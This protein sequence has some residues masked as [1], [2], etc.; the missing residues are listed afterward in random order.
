MCGIV[1]FKSEKKLNIKQL[2][3]CLKTLEY[4]G[5]DS[6]GVAY[7]KNNKI[8]IIKEVGKISNLEKKLDDDY[9][10]I[11]IAHT[12]WATHGGANVKNAH[13]H[14]INKITIVHNG[15]IENYNE[16]KETL[17]KNGYKFKSDTDTEVACALID[18]LYKTN[19]MLN[20]LVEFK[21]IVRG[22][23]ALGIICSDDLNTLYAIRKDSPLII[24]KDNDTLYIA[25]DVPAILNHTNKYMLLESDEIAVLTNTITIYNNKLKVLNKK[26]LTFE[27]KLESAMKNGY[28]HFMLKEINEEPIV[29]NNT[30]SDYNTIEKLINNMPNLKKYN[31]IEIIACGSAYHTGLVGKKLIE[32]YA[33][34]KTNVYVASEYRYSNQFIDKKTLCIFVSQSGETADTLACLRKVKDNDIDT[35]AIVNVIGSSIAREAKHTLYI[36]AGVEIAVATTKAYLAQLTMFSLIALNLSKVNNT[37]TDNEINKLLKEMKNIPELIKQLIKNYSNIAKSIY[38]K[39]DIFFIGRGIDYA[40]C[41]E[42]SLKLKEISYIHSEA[43][44]AGELK[45]GTIS[46]IEKNTPVI[47]II[48]DDNLYEKT[49]SNIKEVKSRGANITLVIKDSL[50]KNIDF[51]DNL[52]VVPTTSTL[53]QSIITI[54]PL[55]L[56]A[57]EI[58]I[59]R[60]CDIDKPRNLAKSVTVE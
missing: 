51:C 42:G 17:I 55:Q 43:Y 34:I 5:Y 28:D 13:P 37:L 23:Y 60:K 4:R 2:I 15:I 24:A 10:N 35:L 52:I 25:S 30:I 45:H 9:T 19:D 50:N 21:K 20:T 36:K 57:Y 18:Y 39:E 3:E 33:N 46:L 32:E 59:L 41:E 53:F 8:K 1:G 7:I 22:S 14:I 49:I 12:R 11:G 56:L 48:T 54:V 27:G 29:F 44:A 31:N 38:N 58:A 26:I 6:S 16:I 47:S 40:L